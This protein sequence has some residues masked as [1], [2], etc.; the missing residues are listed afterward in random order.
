MLTRAV[1]GYNETKSLE[2]FP[3]PWDERAELMSQFAFVAWRHSMATESWREAGNWLGRFRE[4]IDQWTVGR[5]T[6][7]SLVSGVLDTYDEVAPTSFELMLTSGCLRHRGNDNPLAVATLAR[8]LQHVAE[9]CS[10][11]TL[12][13]AEREA[14]LFDFVLL[15]ARFLRV[16]G[17]GRKAFEVMTRLGHNQEDLRRH[18][19]LLVELEAE[20]ISWRSQEDVIQCV[21]SAASFLAQRHEEW[22]RRDRAKVK[23]AL[24]NALIVLGCHREAI[25]VL[26]EIVADPWLARELHIWAV[27]RQML[28]SAYLQSG[29]RVLGLAQLRRAGRQSRGLGWSLYLSFEV[30]RA[31][32]LASLGDLQESANVLRAAAERYG[33]TGEVGWRGYVLFLLG[34]VLSDLGRNKEAQECL[35]RAIADLATAGRHLDLAAAKELRAALVIREAS[36]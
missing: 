17:E 14:I 6:A 31:D 28:G 26:K 11:P 27:G 12:S 16:A 19:N 8:E 33:E 1:G 4:A 21:A 2:P 25:A 29:E 24:G 5:A 35:D 10:W 32:A 13:A 34:E 3:D 20:V 30:N 15:E 18:V 7:A 22:S 36:R 23:L 9:G